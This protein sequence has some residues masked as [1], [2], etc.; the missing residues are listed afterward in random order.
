M[1]VSQDRAGKLS[2]AHLVLQRHQSGK[3]PD[4]MGQKAMGNGSTCALELKQRS[5]DVG[6]ASAHVSICQLGRRKRNKGRKKGLI[7]IT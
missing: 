2:L 3:S 1:R 4:Q 6:V 5:G 7:L